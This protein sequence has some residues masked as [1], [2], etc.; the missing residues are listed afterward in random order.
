MMLQNKEWRVHASMV[1]YWK[2]HKPVRFVLSYV[3]SVT[4]QYKIE[5]HKKH[6]CNPSSHYRKY[7]RFTLEACATFLD[8]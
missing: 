2:A 4:Q 8:V 5:Q 6:L 7:R 3:L 1:N